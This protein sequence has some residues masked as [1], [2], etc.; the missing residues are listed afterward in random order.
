M[1]PSRRGA[2][3]S[4]SAAS[5]P[6][7]AGR[8][9]TPS[10]PAARASRASDAEAQKAALLPL[11]DGWHAPVCDAIAAT[12]AAAIL[13]HDVY[14]R[15]PARRTHGG[16]VV[17]VGDAAHAATPDLGQSGAMALED[18]VALAACLAGAASVPEALDAF[19]RRPPPR[20][21][22]IT[23]QSR[24]AARV[25]QASGRA[26]RVRNAALRASPSAAFGALFGWAFRGG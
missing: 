8:T 20:T 5:T 25:G 22:M 14:D 19:A 23:R 7:L 17:L 18:A 6:A 12:P 21:A 16:R 9:G 3:A 11:F 4:A 10:R 1:R 13:C 26:G 24:V 2:T 15:P